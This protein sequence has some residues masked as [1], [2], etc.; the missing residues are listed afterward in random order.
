MTS[1][2]Y[3][4]QKSAEVTATLVG[5]FWR[6][7]FL[8][9]YVHQYRNAKHRVISDDLQNIK[10]YCHKQSPFS[11]VFT[12][13]GG[14]LSCKGVVTVRRVLIPFSVKGYALSTLDY[15]LLR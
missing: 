15:N 4:P 14:A 8:T 5:V 1:N 12:D 2:G 9:F 7:L 6:L 11:V 10:Y 3:A 13:R